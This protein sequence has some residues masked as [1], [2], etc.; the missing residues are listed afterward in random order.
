MFDL[1]RNDRQADTFYSRTI[2]L[3]EA[4]FSKFDS[5]VI[6]KT[7]IRQT[8][9]R[10]GCCDGINFQFVSILNS[11][12]SV[13][14]FGNLNIESDTIGCKIIVHTLDN[15][16]LFYQDSVIADYFNDVKSYIYDTI[17][18]I[19]YKDNRAI[20]KLRKIEYSR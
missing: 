12:T 19:H 13:L 6:Q 2:L 20:N 1:A 8:P 5:A 9:Q 15:F 10:Q 4:Q 17:E 3:S 16:A 11:D 14:H 18:P 7:K